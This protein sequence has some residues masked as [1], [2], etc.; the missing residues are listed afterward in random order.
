MIID[1]TDDVPDIVARGGMD[2]EKV[3]KNDD[4]W[5]IIVRQ[6]KNND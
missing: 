3:I 2:V 1:N 6:S 4:I 5:N